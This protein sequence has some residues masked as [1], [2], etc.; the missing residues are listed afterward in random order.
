MM[1]RFLSYMLFPVIMFMFVNCNKQNKESKNTKEEII[2]ISSGNFQKL[3]SSFKKENSDNVRAS[4][5]PEYYAGAFRDSTGRLVINIIGDSLTAKRDII[6]RI[7]NE[8]FLLQEKKYSYTELSQ[9][10]DT[11]NRFMLNSTNKKIVDEIEIHVISLLDRENKIV[12]RLGNLNAES[13]TAFKEKVYYSPAI[14]FAQSPG[15]P[16]LH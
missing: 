9:I 2:R 5:Y 16:K 7:G 3:M 1:K 10:M 13:I 15:R 14:H 4:D 12:V 8:H 11:I 6:E